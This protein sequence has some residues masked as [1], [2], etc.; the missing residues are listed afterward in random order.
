M[1]TLSIIEGFD[2]EENISPC[3]IAGFVIFVMYL[4]PFE[5]AEKPFHERYGAHCYLVFASNV[6]ASPMKHLTRFQLQFAFAVA[7]PQLNC[8]SLEFWRIISFLSCLFSATTF[9][10]ED[11]KEKSSMKTTL[12]VNN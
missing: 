7:L 11:Q 2:V 10:R 1:V 6:R 3:R 5:G 12:V 8:F 4:F 9:F